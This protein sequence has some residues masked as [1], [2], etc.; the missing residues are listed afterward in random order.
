MVG[1]GE[2]PHA[3]RKKFFDNPE[4]ILGK[5]IKYK[6]FPKGVKDKPR[7]PTFK[8]FRDKADMV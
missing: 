3:D 4:L 1:A 7:F 6:H 8:T 5:I 2:M